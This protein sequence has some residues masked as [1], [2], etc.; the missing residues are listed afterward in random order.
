MDSCFAAWWTSVRKRVDRPRH[1]A[2]DS[3]VIAVAWGIWS[4]R[5]DRVFR[6]SSQGAVAV[7]D[8]IWATVDLWC[9]AALVDRSQ[10]LAL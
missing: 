5:N 7:V 4:Q 9:R 1:R 10:L 6:A 3:L 2:F 8:K